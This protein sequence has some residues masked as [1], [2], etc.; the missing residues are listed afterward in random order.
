MGLIHKEQFA[1]LDLIGQ[2]PGG[3]GDIGASEMVA[4]TVD[5]LRNT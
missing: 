5:N 1:T 3:P 4:T 2:S